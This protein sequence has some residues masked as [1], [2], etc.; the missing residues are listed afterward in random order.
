[1]R[2]YELVFRRLSKC[3]VGSKEKVERTPTTLVGGKF[4]FKGSKWTRLS[5]VKFRT[6]L[7]Q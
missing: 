3:N 6:L 4:E 1:M 7:F 2:D 5:P